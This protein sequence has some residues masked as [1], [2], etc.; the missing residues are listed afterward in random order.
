MNIFVLDK[1]PNIAAKYHCDKHV[2][3]MITESA[4]MLSTVHHMCGIP[5]TMDANEIYLKAHVNHPCTIW[6]RKTIDNYNWLVTLG[7][8]LCE[9][10]TWRYS[11]KVHKTQKVLEYLKKH[12]PN[13]SAVGLTPFELCMPDQFKVPGYPIISYRNF[14]NKDK[15][16]FA[17]WKHG[18][19]PTWF[20][21]EI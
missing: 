8:C 5:D 15:A 13:I 19:I 17:E 16:R 6:V 11:N 18:N 14:Y 1:E 9:E 2:V 3:K 12:Q 10:Y 20:K 7:L 21:K 4:Q